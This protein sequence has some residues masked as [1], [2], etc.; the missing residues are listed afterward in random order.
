MEIVAARARPRRP[1]FTL[2]ELLV[3]IAIISVLI[4]LLLP[5]IQKVRESAARTQCVNN[6][7][8]LGLGLHNYHTNQGG[9][10][11]A[12]QDLPTY[13]GGP[14]TPK[15]SWVPYL[16]PFIDL[17]PLQSTY[18]MDRDW[19]DKTNDGVSPYTG[20]SA[21]P[22]QTQ[23]PLLIC[24]SA[25]SSRTGSNRR[26]VTDYAPPN[27]IGRPN[28]FYTANS[29]PPS[30]STRIGILGY[31]VKRKISDVNDGMSN[32]MMLAEDAGRNEWWIMGQ[33]VSSKPSNF[34]SGGE[35]GAWANPGSDITTYGFNPA[36]VGT[37]NPEQPGP[38]AVNCTNANEIYAFH[39]GLANVL[40]GDG[41]VRSLRAGTSV[42]VVIPLITRRSHD[43]I[44]P[45][46]LQ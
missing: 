5:A 15:L 4:G 1:G 40:M 19:Q 14:T 38:C 12:E 44:P 2:I 9:F 34:V 22:N 33:F 31:N 42:N 24:P 20:S 29:M 11:P 25:P 43:L 16:M 30:D 46:A 37:K 23:I 45:D 18:R 41:S 6:L 13:A 17:A 8:Q 21:G 32:T 35:S 7:K 39:L 3:V 10:P 26:G 28:P 27:Q 36:S